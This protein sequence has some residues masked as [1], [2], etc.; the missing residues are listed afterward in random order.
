MVMES[1]PYDF[2]GRG[3]HDHCKCSKGVLPENEQIQK[4]KEEKCLPSQ[5]GSKLKI[6]SPSFDLINTLG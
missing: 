4:V 3:F 5:Q 1:S 6:N 2:I